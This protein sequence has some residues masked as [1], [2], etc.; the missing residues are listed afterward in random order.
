MKDLQNFKFKK[1]TYNDKKIHEFKP[2]EFVMPKMPH[3]KGI[4]RV[5]NVAKGNA[6]SFK[7]FTT[8]SNK[9]TSH[10]GNIG[11]NK[12]LMSINKTKS[13]G[14]KRI[15]QQKG[16]NP[17]NDFDGDGL[18]N[19]LDCNPRNKFEQGPE[20][21]I[22]DKLNPSDELRDNFNEAPQSKASKLQSFLINNKQIKQE[23]ALRNADLRRKAERPDLHRKAERQERASIEKRKVAM[24]RREIR[25]RE[26]SRQTEGQKVKSAVGAVGGAVSTISGTTTKFGGF[27]VNQQQLTPMPDNVSKRNKILMLLGKEPEQVQAPIPQQAQTPVQQSAP[28]QGG[29]D[30]PHSKRRVSYVRGP[31]KK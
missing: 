11:F 4:D 24:L 21:T 8:S 23:Q 22:E 12:A 16:L 17:F 20:H 10:K 7:K 28:V 31:Y 6:M 27:G 26:E 2:K 30:S 19:M 3:N 13:M 14:V 18:I 15:K 29:V 25:A 1:L 9:I 5:R